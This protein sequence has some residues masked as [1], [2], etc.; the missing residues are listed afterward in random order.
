MNTLEVAGAISCIYGALIKLLTNEVK[1]TITPWYDAITLDSIILFFIL[2][3]EYASTMNEAMN[4][5]Y[6]GLCEEDI[7]LSKFNYDIKKMTNHIC[8]AACLIQACGKQ[9]SRQ[10]FIILFEQLAKHS[11]NIQSLLQTMVHRIAPAKVSSSHSTS[12]SPRPIWSTPASLA[13]INTKMKK[14]HM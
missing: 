2:I 10:T 5:V 8:G 1:A 7:K 13:G 12:S 3:Q 9:I 11:L 6:D 14:N 4:I